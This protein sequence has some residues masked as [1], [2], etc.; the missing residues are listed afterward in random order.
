MNAVKKIDKPEWI[1]PY[2]CKV[3]EV[4]NG[5][6]LKALFV[7]G[8]VRNQLMGHPVLDIDVATS[9]KPEE[10]QNILNAIKIKTVPT[11]I[12]HGTI[13]AVLDNQTIEITTLRQDIKTDGRH[14]QTEWTDDWVEDARRRDFT[15]NTL[16]MDLDGNVFDPLGNGLA[17]VENKEIKFVGEPAKRI[18]ED[19]LRVLRYFRF[20]AI[21]GDGEYDEEALKACSN[22]AKQIRILSKERITQEF[23]KILQSARC[24]ETLDVMF[25]YGVLDSL[26]NK[27][28]EAACLNRFI[29]LQAK[30]HLDFTEPNHII[31]SRLFCSQGNKPIFHDDYLRFSKAQQQFYVKLELAF[32]PA[33]YLSEKGLKR[34]IF[35]HEKP[36]LFQGYLLSVAN[37]LIEVDSTIIDIFE[38]WNPPKFPVTGKDLMNEGYKT[39]PEL[40]Q[41]LE[42]RREEWLEENI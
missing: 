33:L 3:L 8:C 32:N 18:E 19:A 27:N 25:M 34:A 36:L 1:T 15:L 29:E 10:V 5:E 23:F 42:R 31:V 7:G 39:G 14:A 6:S 28:F 17:A 35:N 38:N 22:A 11:G 37:G 16:L 2:V 40:G 41:E 21:Y 26:Q 13:T 30:H 4:L 20:Q 9:L 12:E 24:S